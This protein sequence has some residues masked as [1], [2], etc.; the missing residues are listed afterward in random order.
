MSAS[1]A[2]SM[3]TFHDDPW[4]TDTTGRNVF[5]IVAA[6]ASGIPPVKIVEDI[7]RHVREQSAAIYFTKIDTAEVRTLRALAEAGLYVVDVSVT[8][9][10]DARRVEG[11][12]PA[13]AAGGHQT[14][15]GLVVAEVQP[16]QH[17]AVLDIAASSFRFS[18]FHLDPLMDGAN[19]IKR[20]WV[21]SYLRGVRGDRLFAA[22][23]NGRTVGFL[24][25]LTATLED[26]PTAMIDLIGVEPSVQRQ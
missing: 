10:L 7:R 25:A 19:R 23:L 4:L 14:V 6:S 24:A 15:A 5:R 8:F 11:V 26:R 20:E 18:R 2:D 16:D 21:R 1:A 3:V 13:D 22:S 12:A 17:E 9:R